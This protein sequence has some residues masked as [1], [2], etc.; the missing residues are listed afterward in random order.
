[1]LNKYF[2]L[3]FT[4][5]VILCLAVFLIIG[6]KTCAGR[7]KKKKTS[8]SSGTDT[9]I[10]NAPSNLT[11][12]AL[13]YSQINLSWQD[14]S[15]NE[16][17]FELYNSLD[18]T[19]F[20]LLTSFSINVTSYIDNG[21]SQATTYYYRVR[22]MNTV[23][24]R[25]EWSNTANA[26][27]PSIVQGLVWTSASAGENH[28][29][30][31]TTDGSVWTWGLNS[32]W[33]QLGIGDTSVTSRTYPTLITSDFDYQSFTGI[34]AIVA[35][36]NHSLV[37]KTDGSLWSWG[38]NGGGQL[39]TG[40]TSTTEAPF[41]VTTTVIGG[42]I[43]DTDWLRVAAGWRHSIGIKSTGTIWAWGI[44]DAGQLGDGTIIDR[45]TPR[46]IGTGLDWSV[47]AAGEHHTICIKGNLAGGGTLWALGSNDKG[48]LGDGTQGSRYTPKQIGTDS[49]W[50]NIATGWDHTIAIKTNG[51]LWAWGYNNYGQLGDG[52]Q[53]DRD[54]PR[55]IGSNLDWSQASAGYYHTVALKSNNTLWAWGN[56]EYGK[57]GD[58]T[59]NH[60]T[61]PRQIGTGSD[62]SFVSAGHFHSVG[63]KTDN[64]IWTWGYNQYGQLGLG[65]KVN[66]NIPYLV[67]GNPATP[68][69]LTVT[70]IG[71]AQIELSWQ[72]NSNNETD[73]IIERGITNTD[74]SPIVTVGANATSYLDT[75]LNPANTYYYRVCAYNGF[76][77]SPYVNVSTN[78]N[79]IAPSPLTVTIN[80]LSEI[81][82]NWPDKSND[83][84]GFKIE[85]KLNSNGTYD[86]VVPQG[87]I[88]VGV[89]SW[90]DSTP[91][92]PG[93][94]FYYRIRAW[95]AFGDSPYSNEAACTITGNWRQI[96]AGG[97][98]AVGIK[99]N[100]S[101]SGTLW[102]WGYNGSG[103]LGDGTTTNR[104]T[105][106]QIGT[107]SD[108]LAV[109]LTGTN[110]SSIAVGDSHTI[111]LKSSG[112][113]WAWGSNWAG[114]LGDGTVDS[115]TTPRQIGT[116]SDWVSVTTGA[117][118]TI[119]L[120]S[121]M[122]LW[123]WGSN[124]SGQLGDGTV[125]NRLTPRQ[126]GIESDW[127][128]ITAG[129]NYTIGL[130]SAGTLW[131][132]GVNNNG[133][134]GD[135]TQIQRDTPKQI[136]TDSDWLAMS[137]TGTNLSSVAAGDSHTIALKTTG[138][139][140]AWGMNNN[141]Q[142][143]DDSQTDRSTPR[144]IGTD[145][146]WFSVTAGYAHTIGIKGNPVG[147]ATIWAWGANSSGR[148]GDGTTTIRITPRQIGSELDWSS[149]DKIDG[150]SNYTI[151]LKSSGMLWVWGDNQFGQLGLGDIINRKTPT[152]LGE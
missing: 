134:L 116:E 65:D 32:N 150:G 114:Q 68:L 100:P 93:A 16:D 71:L 125:D 63:I 90:S 107:E 144:Q 52:S 110:L 21:L 64:T 88:G 38:A 45:Y 95:N 87:V 121:T 27:I 86:E 33:W 28:T 101:G 143:G 26:T 85:R 79:G 122:T 131:A 39:G 57:L 6:A 80:E 72:D 43:L 120:K 18:N 140:W 23:G 22:A 124:G 59:I 61:T 54:S 40:D 145:S 15:N 24:D 78:F 96:S 138:T 47:A 30:A 17:G 74:Y 128:Y 135:G 83:E 56:N 148:L 67:G 60:R 44:N 25:S 5:A 14:N 106:R 127:F 36:G 113:L 70:P 66:R 112:L 119:G 69:S 7:D 108:W 111:A 139:L 13:S 105:P 11:A 104:T 151:V 115:R 137:L 141:G 75:G 55:M 42:T 29:I 31:L 89:T 126:I 76:G 132:W 53:T 92:S 81:I 142:L 35:G 2:H 19:N 123:A 49:D 91:I 147:G 94:Y 58:G 84:T 152:L 97:L 102:V 109:S 12:T 73:F 20:Q 118:H 1:M 51:Q 149:Q 9:F 46:Q 130:K 146:D 34:T 3:F 48:Q 129:A 10:I 8:G 37:L 77:S 99:S 98:H 133:Q 103:R 136:G 50:V 117:N 4:K 41:P 62:W 82:L